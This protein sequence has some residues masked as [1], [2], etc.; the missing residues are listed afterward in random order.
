M[1]L[2]CPSLYNVYENAGLIIE[3]DIQWIMHHD[4][5]GLIQF[6]F[7]VLIMICLFCLLGIDKFDIQ[8]IMHCDTFKS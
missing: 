5:Y 4:I 6:F 7:G 1:F 8:W 3:F 2:S